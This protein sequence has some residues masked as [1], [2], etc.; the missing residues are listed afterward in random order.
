MRNTVYFKRKSPFVNHSLFLKNKL[1]YVSEL[2]EVE[3]SF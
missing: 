3:P 2:D 1:N